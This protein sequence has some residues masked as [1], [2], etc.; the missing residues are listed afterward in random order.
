MGG[1]SLNTE[2]VLLLFSRI[3]IMGGQIWVQDQSSGLS[4]EHIGG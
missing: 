1:K 3:K 4:S 2:S